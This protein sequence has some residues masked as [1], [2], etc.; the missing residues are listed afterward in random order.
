MF[1]LS[2]ENPLINYY[3]PFMLNSKIDY[4]QFV[5]TKMINDL[6]TI[7]DQV[8]RVNKKNKIKQ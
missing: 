2:V 5:N 4:L 7:L 6:A 1:N 3:A 8:L